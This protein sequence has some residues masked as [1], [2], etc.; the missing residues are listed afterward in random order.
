MAW[1]CG[2]LTGDLRL[3]WRI[4]GATRGARLVLEACWHVPSSIDTCWARGRSGR[5]IA[6]A[7]MLRWR[8]FQWQMVDCP[9][10]SLNMV[11]VSWIGARK[12]F[13]LG[14]KRCGSGE[15][16]NIVTGTFSSVWRRVNYPMEV[17]PPY[18]GRLGDDCS[19]GGGFCLR[20]HLEHWF[21]RLWWFGGAWQPNRAFQ[22]HVRARGGSNDDDLS[23]FCRSNDDLSDGWGGCLI[24]CL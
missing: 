10:R 7:W 17:F 23:G 14:F 20:R 16:V 9:P 13:D 8:R 3:T 22:G 18:N 11:S 19:V 1:W 6:G 5:S 2:K 15:R 24:G 4:R 12:A 21:C